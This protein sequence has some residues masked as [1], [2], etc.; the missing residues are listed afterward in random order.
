MFVLHVR[1]CISQQYTTECI[2]RALSLL[3][4]SS[5]LV[6]ANCSAGEYLDEEQN[7]CKP[8][9][10]SKYQPEKWQTQ[11]RDCPYGTT[12]LVLGGADLKDCVRSCPAGQELIVADN[13]CR[14]C[15]QNQYR[16]P[17]ESFSCT[18]CPG[19]TIAPS[20]G[21]K[22][23]DQCTWPDCPEGYYIM[24]KQCMA[25]EDGTYQ[26]DKWKTSCLLC[27]SYPQATTG[28]DGASSVASCQCKHNLFSW[29][30]FFCRLLL[31]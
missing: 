16:N 18:D 11:C 27:P 9:P 31:L 10:L 7:V 23:A 5:L 8:C 3:S 28:G 17:V 26:P 6:P 21:A 12:T 2:E 30:F 4:L 25:C 19:G 1:L 29:F 24:D 22:S 14:P 13:L 15:P 20:Q